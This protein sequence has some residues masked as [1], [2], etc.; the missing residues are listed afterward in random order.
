VVLLISY[1]LNGSE[2][3]KTYTAVADAI[4]KGAASWRRPLYSQWWVETTSTP[5]Q[6]VDYLKSLLDSN[7][8]LL[9]TQMRTPYQG[10]LSKDDWSWLNSRL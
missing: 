1:D 6:W 10:W 8:R 4:K 2:R 9:V 3:P 5:D 7:D